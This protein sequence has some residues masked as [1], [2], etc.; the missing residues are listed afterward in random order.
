MLDVGVEQDIA[1]MNRSETGFAIVDK[2][3]E[4][5]GKFAHRLYQIARM[6]EAYNR[7]S[8]A[9]AAFELAQSQPAVTK[10][11][12]LSATEYAIGVVEDTQGNFSSIDAP[13]LLKKLPKVTGQYHKY[14]FMYVTRSCRIVLRSCW[15]TFL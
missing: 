15:N 5:A 2:G 14:Q 7:V 3:S 11:L 8:T 1:E 6:V 13:L 9:T 12:G 10:R 4:A